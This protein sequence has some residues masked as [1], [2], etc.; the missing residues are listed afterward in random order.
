MSKRASVV[1]N[2]P[3]AKG[4]ISAQPEPEA[5]G[6]EEITELNVSVSSNGKAKVI[7]IVKGQIKILSLRTR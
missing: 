5:S 6:P 7:K 1:R 3:E 2:E 4:N